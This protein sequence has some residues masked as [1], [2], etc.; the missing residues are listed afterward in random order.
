MTT[1]LAPTLALILHATKDTSFGIQ[2]AHAPKVLSLHKIIRSGDGPQ[3]DSGRLLSRVEAKRF[4]SLLTDPREAT[5]STGVTLLPDGLLQD[6]VNELTWFVKPTR[7]VQHW[8]TAAGREKLDAVLPGLVF[9]AYCG[10]LYVAAYIGDDRP[11]LNTPLFHCPLGNVNRDT[12]VCVGNASL[13]TRGGHETIQAWER[14]LLGTNFSHTNH[15][16]TLAKET[17]TPELIAFWRGRK[18]H[19]TPPQQKLLHPLGQTLG[20]WLLTIA[21]SEQ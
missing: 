14:V 7:R 3:L 21:E 19:S 2:S 5:V 18:R 12:S 8:R 17:S 1:T 4:A 6:A 11:A 15:E 10:T 20:Q 13:P 16:H 9:H